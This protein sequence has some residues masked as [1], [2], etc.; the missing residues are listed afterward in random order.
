MLSEQSLRVSAKQG[1]DIAGYMRHW[2][3]PSS[4]SCP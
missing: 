4:D 2:V 1:T 3:P